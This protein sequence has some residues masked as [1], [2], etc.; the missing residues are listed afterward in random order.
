MRARASLETVDSFP[1]EELR[2][3]SLQK[4]LSMYEVTLKD[5]TIVLLPG[6]ITNSKTLE[7]LIL[8][9]LPTTPTEHNDDTI[10]M[11]YLTTVQWFSTQCDEV[12]SRSSSVVKAILEQMIS[13]A[14]AVRQRARRTISGVDEPVD[15]RVLLATLFSFRARLVATHGP[16]LRHFLHIT[17]ESF[18]QKLLVGMEDW[19]AF[20]LHECLQTAHE[21]LSTCESTRCQWISHKCEQ[22]VLW[23]QECSLLYPQEIEEP[24]TV[25]I[26][27]V[28]DVD[29]AESL[30]SRDTASSTSP[31]PLTVFEALGLNSFWV[32]CTSGRM[33]LDEDNRLCAPGW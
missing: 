12:G 32:A 6:F 20:Y 7:A 26:S 16:L 21:C 13:A 31:S 33:T 29:D 25:N 18:Q 14:K 24:L 3:R 19:I 22:D 15:D 28:M 8:L 1:V 11:L 17:A 2:L 23:K 9:H 10:N 27:S 5:A 4:A 30:A